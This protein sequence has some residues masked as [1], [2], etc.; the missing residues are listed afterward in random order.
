MYGDGPCGPQWVL[1]EGAVDF[2]CDLAVA[3]VDVVSQVLPA[4]SS[5]GDDVAV[6]VDYLYVGPVVVVDEAGDGGQLAV[7]VALGSR[8]VVL[9]KH[10][11]FANFYLHR[12]LDGHRAVGVVA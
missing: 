8:R 2:L 7:V 3:L 10:H 12:A 6:V 4:F 9:D 1:A 11:T 5:H